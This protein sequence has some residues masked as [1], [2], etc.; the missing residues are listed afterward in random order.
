MRIFQIFFVA[1]LTVSGQ[2]GQQADAGANLPA[3]SV[4]PADLLALSVYGA[5]EFTRTVRVSEDGN[6]RLPMLREPIEANGLM[7][8]QLET[9]IAEALQYNQ[10]LV[11]PQVTVTIAEY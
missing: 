11:D 4:G 6:I 10:I 1:G 5:P 7:P 3:K 2:V 8:A 9:S